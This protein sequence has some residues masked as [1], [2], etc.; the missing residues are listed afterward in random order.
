MTIKLGKQASTDGQISYR[1]KFLHSVARPTYNW[2]QFEG[3]MKNVRL[4]KMPRQINFT[5]PDIDT[6]CNDEA[7]AGEHHDA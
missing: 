4:N 3:Y 5:A 2:S 6:T 7:G 1:A